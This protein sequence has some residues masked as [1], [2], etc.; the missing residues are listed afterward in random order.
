[1]HESR[2]FRA[3]EGRLGCISCHDPHRRPAPE[4]R[5]SYYRERCLECHADRGCRLPETARLAAEPRRRLHRLPHAA[6][7]AIR[8]PPRRRRPT[9]ASPAR[10][11]RR[12]IADPH[13]SRGT[14]ERPLVLFHRDLMDERERAAAERDIGVALCRDGPEVAAI[15][16]P[17]LEAALAARPDDLVAWEAKGTVLGQL[18]RF[19]EAWPAFRTALAQEPDREFALI[20]RGLPRRPGGTARGRHRLLAA[21]HRHQPLAHGLPRRAGRPLLRPA[22]IG[23]PRPRPAGRP[24]ASTPPTSRPGSCSSGAISAWKTSRPPAA[25]SRPSWDSIPPTARS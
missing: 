9:I 18:G 24:S 8:H 1:M 11:T 17:L 20:G 6:I 16:L 10:P 25:N 3:S 23:R 21:R 4:E 14:G 19:E 13:R 7:G 12:S 15:A 2:C 22:A 5:A